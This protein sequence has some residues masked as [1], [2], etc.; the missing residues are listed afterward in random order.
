MDKSAIYIAGM[1]ENGKG[2]P[3]SYIHTQMGKLNV[4]FDFIE[5]YSG[6]QFGSYSFLEEVR[7]TEEIIK[8]KQPD[9][10]ISHS[11]G[12]YVAVL[13]PF[14]CPIVLLDPSLSISDIILPNV[15]NSRYNDGE[16]TF[17]LYQ[18]FLD[19]IK[20][21]LSIEDAAKNIKNG[22]R[23]T[24]VGAGKGGYKVAERY[25]D[26]IFGSQYILLPNADHGF[27]EEIDQQKIL[28]IIKKWLGFI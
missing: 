2:A 21:C 19:S 4:C 11:L 28:E 9:I 25:R 10:I 27:S 23:V 13:L 8:E 12:A 24:I 1:F 17:D 20:S 3:F 14:R 26:N 6:K 15:K 7:R 18:S 16:N 5:L 22:E